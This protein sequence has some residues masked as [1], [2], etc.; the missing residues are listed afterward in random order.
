MK[1]ISTRGLIFSALFAAVII[2][3][4]YLKIVL[5]ISPVPI[6]L[7]TLAI[8]LTGAILGARYGTL[9][10]LL[11]LLLVAAGF[12]VLGGRGGISLLIGPSAGFI[13]AWPFATF[14][15][16]FFAQRIKKDQYTFVKLLVI[17]FVFG[18]LFLYPSGVGWLAYKTGIDSLS[19]ALTGGMWP[20]LP[21]DFA[22]ALVS[23]AVVTSVWKVYSTERIIGL[24]EKTA[25]ESV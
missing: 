24:P 22:K 15:I 10:V 17:T 4:S 7:T 1:S 23:S 2:A 6:T 12:P 13:W 9:S 18:S 3:I 20:F 21:G 11:V 5:P 19:K 14:L 8:M 25:H 16:G